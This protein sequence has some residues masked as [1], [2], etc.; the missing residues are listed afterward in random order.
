MVV[1]KE[2]DIETRCDLHLAWNEAGLVPAIAIEAASGRVLM[3]AW[4]NV[5]AFERTLATGEVHYYSRSRRRLWKKGETSGAVQR[6]REV[7]VDCD[8]DCILL[9]VEQAGVGACHTG[10]RSCFYRRV[11]AAD[12]G[13][14]RLEFIAQENPPA[15]SRQTGPRDE[16]E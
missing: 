8:Q 6:V 12:D 3:L 2:S 16:E 11:R 7:R 10:A 13:S 14:L 9:L 1:A 5:E 4:M 15:P